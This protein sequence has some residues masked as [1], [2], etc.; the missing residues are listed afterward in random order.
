MPALLQSVLALGN[1]SGHSSSSSSSWV[2]CHLCTWTSKQLLCQQQQ[3]QQEL[4]L[5]MLGCAK[6]PLLC[7]TLRALHCKLKS[8]G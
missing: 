5:Q 7:Q 6:L 2:G 3:Q 8:T 1:L 4:L